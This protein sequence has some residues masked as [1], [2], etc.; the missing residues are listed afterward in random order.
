MVQIDE[1]GS[2]HLTD[3]VNALISSFGDPKQIA[4]F[5]DGTIFDLVSKCENDGVIDACDTN[6]IFLLRDLRNMFAGLTSK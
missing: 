1:T 2:K 6:R 3:S 5:I 4:E